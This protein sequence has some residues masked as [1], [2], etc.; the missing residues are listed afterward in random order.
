MDQNLGHGGR[1]PRRHGNLIGSVHKNT[2]EETKRPLLGSLFPSRLLTHNRTSQPEN[3]AR[4]RLESQHLRSVPQ[5]PDR[6]HRIQNRLGEGSN[7]PGLK[8]NLDTKT[9]RQHDLAFRRYWTLLLDFAFWDFFLGSASNSW[10]SWPHWILF[11]LKPLSKPGESVRRTGLKPS[12]YFSTC[13]YRKV[14]GE[15]D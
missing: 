7:Q 5:P 2:E 14:P 11:G 3:N 12:V 8:S 15:T 9:D 1:A 13:D 6:F 4:Y 10:A